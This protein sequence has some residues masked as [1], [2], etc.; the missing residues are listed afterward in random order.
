MGGWVGWWV[1]VSKSVDGY[2]VRRCGAVL[3][4]FVGVGGVGGVVCGGGVFAFAYLRP[5]PIVDI[6]WFNLHRIIM[7][8]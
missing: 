1:V 3:R 8:R 5:R 4:C 7:V 6:G 2:V